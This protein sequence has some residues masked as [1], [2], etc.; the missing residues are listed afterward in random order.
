MVSLSHV[1]L[2]DYFTHGIICPTI[3]SSST[4]MSEIW[5]QQN[6]HALRLNHQFSDWWRHR[7]TFSEYNFPHVQKFKQLFREKFSPT[8]IFLKKE[9]PKNFFLNENSKDFTAK[10]CR[11]DIFVSFSFH[12][13]YQWVCK[14]WDSHAVSLTSLA[15]KSYLQKKILW[16]W[17]NPGHMSKSSTSEEVAE[18]SRM[19]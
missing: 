13:V 17:E 16:S 15:L 18:S 6:I 7:G 2:L 10:S 14:C 1:T 3:S 8:V 12:K 11:S 5:Y 4:H 19:T 9:L